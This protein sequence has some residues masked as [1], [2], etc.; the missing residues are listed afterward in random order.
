[1][2]QNR[3]EE[4]KTKSERKGEFWWG[5]FGGFFGGGGGGGLFFGVKR[6]RGMTGGGEKFPGLSKDDPT[7]SLVDFI[8]PQGGGGTVAQFPTFPS[9]GDK[10]FIGENL[11]KGVS[12]F[13][14]GGGGVT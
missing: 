10:K 9:L 13:G 12:L 2:G 6:G 3:G 4:K 1:M 11:G 7:K 8:A 14:G 5:V